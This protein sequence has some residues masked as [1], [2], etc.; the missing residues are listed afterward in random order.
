MEPYLTM[1]D[2]T[3]TPELIPTPIYWRG[4]EFAQTK[5]D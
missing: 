5:G 2:I 3:Y 1:S 4:D